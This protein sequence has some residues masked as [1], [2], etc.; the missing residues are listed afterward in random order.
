M[1]RSEIIIASGERYIEMECPDGKTRIVPMDFV[2]R[3]LNN[4]ASIS[5]MEGYQAVLHKIISEWRD[6][7]VARPVYEHG[8]GIKSLGGKGNK[9]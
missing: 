4:T 8:A 5:Q 9:N 2:D 7:V 6:Y 1:K 3:V